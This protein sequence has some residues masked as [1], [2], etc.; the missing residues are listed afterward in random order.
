MGEK[1][2]RFL[3]LLA[4]IDLAREELNDALEL[5]ARTV[6]DTRERHLSGEPISRI[7]HEAKWVSARQRLS[8][9]MERMHHALRVAR[10]EAARL[11]VTKEG[12]SIAEAARILER[13][14]QVIDRLYRQ[15]K[16]E[17]E[18]L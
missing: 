11:I 12:K 5:V 3:N 1:G 15:A 4:E 16:S 8:D 6:E 10:G 9:A 14:R 17:V 7:I 13:P 2:D 18:E